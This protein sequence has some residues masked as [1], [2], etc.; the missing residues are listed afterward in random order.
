MSTRSFLFLLGL[1]SFFPLSTF[2]ADE[3]I[4]QKTMLSTITDP[5]P[6]SKIPFHLDIEEGYLSGDDDRST[7]RFDLRG[8]SQANAE[9]EVSIFTPIPQLISD[10]Q[11]QESGGNLDFSW[12]PREVFSPSSWIF[13]VPP[14]SDTFATPALPDDFWKIIERN[15]TL[16][17]P[18]V[19]PQAC[20]PTFTTS[21]SCD[22]EIKTLESITDCGECGSQF[23]CDTN[24]PPNCNTVCNSCLSC[25]VTGGGT[26]TRSCTTTYSC[27][28]W[29]E[30][31]QDEDYGTV[32]SPVRPASHSGIWEY[33]LWWL[34]TSNSSNTVSFLPKS[35][36]LAA[37]TTS[38]TMK[39]FAFGAGG[40]G[41]SSG[42]GGASNWGGSTG[43]GN[44]GN[45][46]PG[47]GNPGGGGAPG[48]STPPAP[49][50]PQEGDACA[51]NTCSPPPCTPPPPARGLNLIHRA[52]A[53]VDDFEKY[54][55]WYNIEGDS[56]F[57]FLPSIGVVRD[58]SVSQKIPLDDAEVLNRDP[59]NFEI[60]MR[61]A[62]TKDTPTKIISV[63]LL[64]IADFD[65]TT[66]T[67]H[68]ALF[69]VRRIE[70]SDKAPPPNNERD[71]VDTESIENDEGYLITAREE[72]ILAPSG[73]S[74]SP[75]PQK[76]EFELR[77]ARHRADKNGQFLIH[78]FS[79]LHLNPMSGTHAVVGTHQSTDTRFEN[80]EE[81]KSV[82]IGS[83]RVSSGFRTSDAFI[84]PAHTF[85][86]EADPLGTIF[87]AWTK[88]PIN[89][90]ALDLSG[91]AVREGGQTSRFS[92]T[93]KTGSDG[94][95]RFFA[96]IGR[97]N[98]AVRSI[99]EKMTNFTSPPADCE[100]ADY[101]PYSDI[102]CGSEELKLDSAASTHRDIPIAP[103]LF[104]TADAGKLILLQKDGE[105]IDEFVTT[106]EGRFS[107][108]ISPGE[109]ELSNGTD[110]QNVSAP[111]ISAISL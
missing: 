40:A 110:I 83:D 11:V 41:G 111:N 18:L 70:F 79:L 36:R 8:V 72:A 51:S 90:A 108:F 88:I 13:S 78:N 20:Q 82:F 38:E 76:V 95:F 5:A 43:N 99:G 35:I 66:D 64:D 93:E 9:N 61:E 27:S 1:F 31:W 37:L 60:G 23:V 4:E 68:F 98:L 96:P 45:G 65:P 91:M 105:I 47:N 57:P 73:A 17:L 100:T 2:A 48:G 54:E 6:G 7:A 71:T 86:L 30:G 103:T 84:L 55:I 39:L 109:Y 92:A 56:D 50:P 106:P 28:D 81:R 16:T 42:S 33:G 3:Q 85:S 52:P 19:A 14:P 74:N 22:Y 102:F 44:P 101:T 32:T 67:A 10:F 26:K 12:S 87:D 104:G 15:E 75:S 21:T 80:V 62:K 59:S 94:F 69:E 34:E 107:F 24:I 25:Q 77:S 97:Y 46:N 63:P 58:P 49:P 29:W 89:N 53:L